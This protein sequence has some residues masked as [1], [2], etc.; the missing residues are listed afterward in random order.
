M[1][2]LGN[3][4]GCIVFIIFTFFLAEYYDESPDDEY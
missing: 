4:L 3:E 1:N 2:L